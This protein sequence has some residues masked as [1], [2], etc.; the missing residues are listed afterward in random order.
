MTSASEICDAR[1]DGLS[2]LTAPRVYVVGAWP[3]E[4]TIWELGGQSMHAV[5]K[6]E[7][8]IVKGG[9]MPANLWCNFELMASKRMRFQV[10]KGIAKRRELRTLSVFGNGFDPKTHCSVYA[11]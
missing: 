3:K 7:F 10:Q 2:R 11:V 6:S 9:V 8:S 5:A 1:G 4:Y